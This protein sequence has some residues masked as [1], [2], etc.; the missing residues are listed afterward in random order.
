M[1]YF[2]KICISELHTVSVIRVLIFVIEPVKI[3]IIGVI[4]LIRL[5]LQSLNDDNYYD[6]MYM[7]LEF[8]WYIPLYQCK[9]K[10][11]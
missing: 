10:S 4:F 8:N 3:I 1:L 6:T 2:S 7:I 11:V 5:N 9:L